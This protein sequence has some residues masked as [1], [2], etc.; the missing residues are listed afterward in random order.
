[1]LA[2]HSCCHVRL[3][4]IG[5]FVRE[6][7][8]AKTVTERSL[9]ATG[10]RTF[11]KGDGGQNIHEGTFAKGDGGQN[12]HE[13]TFA[14]GDEG[15][16]VCGGTFAKGDGGENVRG[17]TFAKGDG[18]ENVREGTFAKGDG[19]QNVREG[20]FAK[21]NLQGHRKKPWVGGTYLMKDLQ[22][23][24]CHVRCLRVGR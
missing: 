7:S 24:L 18:G 19:G 17:G 23:L 10:D 22:N 12:V 5:A 14:K 2:L 4:A 1:M 13:G 6:W 11:A 3:K 8:R 9:G 20:M 21:G 15:E 16:N